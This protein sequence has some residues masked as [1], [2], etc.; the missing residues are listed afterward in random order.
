MIYAN[1]NSAIRPV[2]RLCSESKY[3]R[4]LIKKFSKAG[5]KN[6]LCRKVEFS[7]V[8]SI[9]ET[10]IKSKIIFRR[11]AAFLNSIDVRLRCSS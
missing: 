9:S 5:I 11:C 1:A 8:I 3:S 7:C 10:D 2:C 4:H 6:E